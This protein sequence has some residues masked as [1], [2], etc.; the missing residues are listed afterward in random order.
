MSMVSLAY[1]SG[2]MKLRDHKFKILLSTVLND[3]RSEKTLNC[4]YMNSE[5]IWK[6]EV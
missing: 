4:E 1:V 5:Y 6:V 3:W 2:I